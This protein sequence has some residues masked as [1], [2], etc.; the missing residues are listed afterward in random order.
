MMRN[1]MFERYLPQQ[2]SLSEMSDLDFN[3]MLIY[4][5][6]PDYQ[7]SDAHQ[8]K[9]KLAK[10]ELL[11]KLSCILNFHQYCLYHDN[12][13]TLYTKTDIKNYLKYSFINKNFPM[14]QR[15]IEPFET[16][17]LL[18]D[19]FE[20]VIGAIYEDS[21]LDQVQKVYKHILSPLILYNT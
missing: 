14:N 15:K 11:A 9:L 10:N 3:Y 5:V 4:K 1:T 20:S 13:T 21:G 7:P 6:N 16:P 2:D 8:A 17:K 12:D 19:I 18:G